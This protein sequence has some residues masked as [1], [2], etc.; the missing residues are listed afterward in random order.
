LSKTFETKK[1]IMEMLKAKPMT[2]TQLCEQLD[3]G[4]S[5][6][7]Q[8]I[9]E[10]KRIGAIKEIENEYSRKWKYYTPDS[11]FD[12]S[13]MLNTNNVSYGRL[14]IFIPVIFVIAII[15]VAAIMLTYYKG[16]L[17]PRQTQAIYTNKTKN[18][19][20]TQN[21]IV[22]KLT[23]PPLVPNNTRAL[24]LSYSYIGLHKVGYPANSGY[25]WFQENGKVNL[26]NLTN[27]AETIGVINVTSGVNFDGISLNISA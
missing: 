1:K 6:I 26:L 10:L 17:K 27:I 15:A 8:H 25:E 9:D 2:V 11:A 4:V 22:V 18:T 16:P 19:I 21:P 14:R 13:K 20:L 3:L 7:S 5:T 24:I 23:D 12:E